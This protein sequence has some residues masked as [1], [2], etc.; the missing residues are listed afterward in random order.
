MKAIDFPESNI[1]FGVGQEFQ[2]L[3]AFQD[4]AQESIPVVF[5]YQ[6]SEEEIEKIKETGVLWF[7]QLTYGGFRPV[8][9]TVH[10]HEVIVTTPLS[11][12]GYD[13]IHPN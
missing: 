6:L 2:N 10:K 4:K 3:H 11:D 7:C 12:L 8:F 5:C 13:G 1:V 9:P